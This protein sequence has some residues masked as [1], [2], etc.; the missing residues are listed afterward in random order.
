MKRYISFTNRIPVGA[1]ANVQ[2]TIPVDV[3]FLV[4]KLTAN[5]TVGL[6]S[7]QT[8]L[9]GRPMSL[10]RITQNNHFGVNTLPC[11]LTAPGYVPAGSEIGLDILD[12]SGFAQVVE[13]TFHGVTGNEKELA[14]ISENF[15][16]LPYFYAGAVALAPLG[17]FPLVIQT[18]A[19]APFRIIKLMA[20]N[21]GAFDA[22]IDV[23]GSYLNRQ[24]QRNVSLFGTAQLPLAIDPY[25][26][27]AR[28]KIQIDLLDTS[29]FA[30]PLEIVL[31]G[32][33]VLK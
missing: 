12:L 4:R 26:V 7:C 17:A 32:H 31:M 24:Y 19:D 9:A 29:G 28:S 20:A 33:K 5:S 25:D 23:N 2:P 15:K 3:P 13:I 1:G 22:R 27:A 16:H 21:V 30:K 6:F 8:K 11:I 18:E 10:G 14:E